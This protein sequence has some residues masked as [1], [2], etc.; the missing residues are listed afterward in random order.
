MF[1]KKRKE[2]KTIVGKIHRHHSRKVS[3]EESIVIIGHKIKT[4]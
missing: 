1:E 4:K 2:S 3:Y